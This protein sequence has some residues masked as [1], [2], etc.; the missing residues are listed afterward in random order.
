MSFLER[1]ARRIEFHPEITVIKGENEVGKSSLIKSIFWTLGCVPAK[2]NDRWQQASVCSA[3]RVAIDGIEYTFL[4]QRDFY[5][6]FDGEFQLLDTFTKV[7]EGL[8]PYFANLVH[9]GLRLPDKNGRVIALPPAY[10]FLPFYADQDGSWQNLWAAFARLEQFRDW[11][12]GV[13]SYH[14]G[15]RGNKYYEAQG[16]KFD[17]ERERDK[18]ARKR[19]GLES[20]YKDLSEKFQAAQFNIDFSAFTNEIEEL[21]HE[22]GVLRA[23]EEEFKARITELRSHQ[24]IYRTQLDIATHAREESFKDYEF[25]TQMHGDDIPCPI[26]GA[27][28]SNSFSER[29]NIAFDENRCAELILELNGHLSEL[30]KSIESELSQANKVTEERVAIER[31]LGRKE[32]EVAIADLINQEGRTELRSVMSA[33][34][35][36]LTANIG[37]YERAISTA[38]EEM[39]ALSGKH[40]VK[41]INAFYSEKMRRY[42]NALEVN[43]VSDKVVAN[44]NTQRIKDTGSELPR[45][46]L[47]YQVAYFHVVAKFGAAA[48]APLVLDSPHQQDQDIKHRSGIMHFLQDEYLPGSQMILAVVNT[49]DVKFAGSEITLDRKWSLLLEEEFEVVSE[50]LQPLVDKAL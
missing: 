14:A 21:L 23:R 20:V 9:F 1:K 7:T 18:E 36:K 4:R 16:R 34:I 17:A 13:I 45:A 29:F 40:R 8:A 3:L 11:K 2:M 37:F 25:A 46:I 35:D 19:E 31:L 33:N 22:C 27:E 28:Y 49:D 5:A 12:R 32:G 26:C 15:I 39:K 30:N 50:R 48:V 43:S 41:E 38:E 24:Q 6:V 44:V 47:A 10:Y 42:L